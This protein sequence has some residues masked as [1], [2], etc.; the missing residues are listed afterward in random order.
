MDK[1]PLCLLGKSDHVI[2]LHLSQG[3]S[4]M[5]KKLAVIDLNSLS[6]GGGGVVYGPETGYKVPH[7]HLLTLGVRVGRL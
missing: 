1:C 7:P 6:Q 4:F 3:G 5:I 2:Y